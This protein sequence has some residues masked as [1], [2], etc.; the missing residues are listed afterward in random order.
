MSFVSDS[1]RSLVRDDAARLRVAACVVLGA[2]VLAGVLSDSAS[3]G[4]AAFVAEHNPPA[5][6]LRALMPVVAGPH[7][8]R[9][10]PED[11]AVNRVL[12]YAPFVSSGGRRGRLVALT[13]DDGPGPYT[14]R[15]VRVLR[16]M[17]VPAT[18]FEV[19]QMMSAF[20]AAAR[21]VRRSFVVGDHTL[22]HPALGPMSMRDQTSQVLDQ[23]AR[24]QV[25]GGRFPRLFRPPYASFSGATLRVLKRLRMLMVLWSVDSEDY[26]RPGTRAIVRNVVSRVRPGAIVLM[27]D[28][29]G[30]REQTARALPSVVRRLRARGY[31]FVTVPRMMLLAP[32]PRARRQRVPPGAGRVQRAKPSRRTAARHKHHRHKT[33]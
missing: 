28:A 27:H 31:R 2:F 13:F 22:S 24:M 32:P 30:P 5:R 21:R 14:G 15:I 10:G 3:H 17:H 20:P 12:A 25:Y 4:E 23:A 19:G 33:R 6:G 18:F 16:R 8:P 29:G 1:A 9:V 26:T 7:V 11:R